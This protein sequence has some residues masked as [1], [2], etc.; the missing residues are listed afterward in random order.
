MIDQKDTDAKE[1]VSSF[2]QLD[3]IKTLVALLSSSP[4]ATYKK[5]ASNFHK[6]VNILNVARSKKIIDL[7]NGSKYCVILKAYREMIAL[8]TDK[9][10]AKNFGNFQ[11]NF[12]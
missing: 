3:D 8:P 5:P 10:L 12:K 7:Q 1:S 4:Y 11:S 9:L 6:I 2:F